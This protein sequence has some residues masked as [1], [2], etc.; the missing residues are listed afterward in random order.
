MSR[1]PLC[2]RAAAEEKGTRKDYF[3]SFNIPAFFMI[4]RTASL[5][6]SNLAT[7]SPGGIHSQRVFLSLANLIYSGSFTAF[8]MA[9]ARIAAISFGNLGGPITKL[10]D[11]Q[12]TSY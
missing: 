11:S 10:V 5:R 1:R 12:L 4:S 3:A 6:L 9:L 7:I 2:P 8:S